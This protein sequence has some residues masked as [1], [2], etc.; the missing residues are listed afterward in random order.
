MKIIIL[1]LCVTIF[2]FAKKPNPN[3]KP[4]PMPGSNY[5]A[6]G[7]DI[8]QYYYPFGFTDSSKYLVNPIFN[9]SYTS[10]NPGACATEFLL[11]P[12]CTATCDTSTTYVGETFKTSSTKEIE[13]VFSESLTV[14]GGY[15]KFTG[16][17]S[18]KMSR[19]VKTVTTDKNTFISA[20]GKNIIYT[21]YCTALPPSDAFL[22]SLLNFPTNC[23]D[24][25]MD[26][27]IANGPAMWGN[28]YATQIGVGGVF[29]SESTMSTSTYS[30]LEKTTMNVKAEANLA[31]KVAVSA[32]G[33]V[34]Y[35]KKI[36]E[37]FENNT[38]G[39][40]FNSY[41]GNSSF[42]W[43]HWVRSVPEF[44]TLV[45]VLR[46]N[47][48]S[49]YIRTLE[50]PNSTLVADAW[51]AAINAYLNQP[52]QCPNDCS[53]NGNCVV[54]EFLNI[55]Q[56]DCYSGYSG[57]DCSTKNIVYPMYQGTWCG[58]NYESGD[59]SFSIPCGA[60]PYCPPGWIE[61]T[62]L[63]DVT[64]INPCDHH[65]GDC[66]PPI[67]V[68]SCFSEQETTTAP[69][70][71]ICGWQASPSTVGGYT[72]TCNVSYPLATACPPDSVQIG[73]A[74]TM[75]TCGLDAIT[76]ITQVLSGTFC[77]LSGPLGQSLVTCNGY[78]VQLACPPGYK[79]FIANFAYIR[80][81]GWP[82]GD[83]SEEFFTCVRI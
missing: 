9:L 66:T 76:N 31:L 83:C 39:L 13:E 34:S 78:E 54:G 7:I 3:P 4:Q 14:K 21:I 35:D 72:T 40:E 63:V 47:L 36:L 25:N 68:T 32:Q 16:S 28:M 73:M 69:E 65:N 67:T 80:W 62:Y 24:E 1:I 61:R 60:G 58:I 38:S 23:T 53:G 81:S 11:P 82:L 17:M 15:A 5:I 56:C 46:A 41:G 48:I 30:Y 20:R 50:F 6:F 75:A 59:I 52:V 45:Q 44:P 64:C 57:Y 74:S 26:I 49:D 8:T 18:E 77:G 43:N 27:C 22:E 19:L 2:I 55:G 12:G 42:V 79:K 10:P 33:S 51:E 70:N 37:T 71:V 29:M